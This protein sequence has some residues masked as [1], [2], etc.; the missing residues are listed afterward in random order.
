MKNEDNPQQ[1]NDQDSTNVEPN[2]K[3]C[4]CGQS[5]TGIC[6][7]THKQIENEKI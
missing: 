6:D 5:K 4:C 2:L 3:P 7:G 1:G